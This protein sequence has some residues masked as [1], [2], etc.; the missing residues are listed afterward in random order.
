[1][2]L[3]DL[4][5]YEYSSLLAAKKSVP[6]GGSC[7]ALVLELACDLGLMSVNFK[8]EKKG[9]ES[10]REEV[11]SLGEKLNLIKTRAN[12][13]IELDGLAYQ[14]VMD[15]F[16]SK[17]VKKI[18]D[19]SLYACEVPYELYR[20][21]F[22]VED[23]CERLFVIAN[24]NIISDAKI[25]SDLAK[26]VRPGCVSNIGCNINQVKEEKREKFLSLLK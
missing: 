22:E 17:D 9:Y 8:I 20:L 16:K 6:G 25:G 3:N 4:T 13:L 26:S 19:A 5:I 23:I 24:K 11:S 18:Q 10:V 15:A 12:E 1:M 14:Q 21:S 7:L 2:K